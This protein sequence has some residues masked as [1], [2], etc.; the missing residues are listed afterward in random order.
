[1][2]SGLNST[3]I[4]TMRPQFLILTPVCVFLGVATALYASVA[5]PV[6][7]LSLILLGALS[8]HI[9]VNTLNEYFDYRS[10]LDSM[11]VKT[12]FSGGS[13]ALMAHPDTLPWVG[14][15]GL[16]ALLLTCAIGIYFIALQGWQILPIG[17]LGVIIVLTYTPWIN[18]H[19]LLCLL[20]PGAGFGLL[21]VIGTS[22]LL[23]G[24]YAPTALLASIVPFFL[25][26]NLLLLNQYPDIEADQKV[27]R[28]HAPIAYG[29]G[30]C[31]LIYALQLAGAALA[32]CAGVAA[33]LFPM[34]SLCA[35]LPLL[36]AVAALYGAIRFATDH[37]RLTPFL[38]LNVA[39]ALLTPLV[40]GICLIW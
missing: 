31:N 30:R 18:R 23:T 40:L 12:P 35:L 15:T 10:G 28:H 19:P 16:L 11:T 34:A 22:L 1:M 7:E 38:G 14:I 24:V 4:Q 39:A 8:A 9:S 20:A 17:L 33:G 21:M 29:V 27:G 2:R 37:E 3:L 26:N 32:V 5:L 25:T 13:G 36:A 6:T